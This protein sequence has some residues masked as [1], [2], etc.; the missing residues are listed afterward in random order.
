MSKTPAPLDASLLGMPKGSAA[1]VA[2]PDA[3]L[4][5]VPPIPTQPETAAP[6]PAPTPIRTSKGDVGTVRSHRKADAR[7]EEEE[8]ALSD[9]A[10]KPEHEPRVALT[11]RLPQSMLTRL[12]E[13]AHRLS[14]PKQEIV[15]F[16]LEKALTKEGY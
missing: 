15:E 6:A 10:R 16:A 5:P 13:A 2:D 9:L 12:G 8:G 14:V 1:K 7:L 3:R 4:P 11:V